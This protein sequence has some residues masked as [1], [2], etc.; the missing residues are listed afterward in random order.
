METEVVMMTLKA[1]RV[2]SDLTQNDVVK[3]L[4]ND[5]CIDITRQKLA[6]YEK[7]STNVSVTLSKALSEIYAISSENIFFGNGSTLSY[8]LRVKELSAS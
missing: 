4:D 8:T 3:I 7:D 1:A 5:Y 6:Q 2:N